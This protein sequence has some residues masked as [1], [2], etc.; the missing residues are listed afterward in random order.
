MLCP[1][2]PRDRRVVPATAPRPRQFCCGCG[3]PR[4]RGHARDRAGHW[5][6][7]NYLD[8]RLPIPSGLNIPAWTELLIDYHDDQ[9]VDF[10]NFGWPVDYTKPTPPTPTY[11]NHE[12]DPVMLR[13][14][15][16]FIQKEVEFGAILG[17]FSQVPFAPWTH[18]SPIMTKPKRD[19]GKY[20]II[21]DLSWPRGQSVNSGVVSGAYLGQ[22][23]KYSLPS[24]ID[25]SALVV[26]HGPGSFVW[27][28]DLAR[29]YRQLRSCPLSAP[30]L[31][32]TLNDNFYLD[33]TP[34]FGCRSSSSACARWT[35]SVV[36]LMR[37]KGFQTLCYLDD[38]VG[39]ESTY[40]RATEA[41]EYFLHLARTL[42]LQLN[43]NKCTPPASTLHWLGY[44]I[45]TIEMK[46]VIPDEKLF[47][48]L[49]Y[50]GQ[51]RYKTRASRKELQK[52]A[53]KL[54]HLST[55]VPGGRRFIS[56]ILTALRL[57]PSTGTHDIVHD[58]AP[59][60]AWFEKYAHRANGI[61][62]LP[63]PIRQT[64]VIEC[65]SSKLGG[66]AFSSSKFFSERYTDDYKAMAGD[67]NNL[68]AINLIVAFQHLAPDNPH[69]YTIVIN[70]DNTATR[71]VLDTGKGKD[72]VLTAC[73]RQ[74]WYLAAR[75]ST[76]V[77]IVHKPGT[78]LVLADA[79]S[80][81]HQS[82]T[83]SKLAKQMVLQQSLERVR[84]SHK[85]TVIDL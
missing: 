28:A 25:L 18:I 55:C 67:I 72:L 29:A 63:P 4:A 15:E 43:I 58:I 6:L 85:M 81:S 62:L 8:A 78:T 70:T 68:E 21:V 50:A 83:S 31:G 27:G 19:P 71:D 5:S 37:K 30:L 76:D 75:M 45:S 64:F 79:L 54:Q 23:S 33:V 10:L 11:T 77:R 12:R 34:S 1:R 3:Y 44:S 48:V 35:N 39:A 16:K 69:L 20:R 26:N 14:I 52:L 65:D 46:I 2:P 9:Q 60:V 40:Q 73:A 42:G 84:V 49:R 32:I 51:W 24:M 47:E 80:R 59:D 41:Y 82:L 7:P 36:W 61:I 53:G 57:T 17:P 56:R 74:L 66:G 13:Y 38:F 22:P